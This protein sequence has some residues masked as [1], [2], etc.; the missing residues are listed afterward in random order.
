MGTQQILMIV[1][2]VIIVGAAVAVGIQMF[3]TQANNQAR[4]A[5]V[6]DLMQFGVQAQAWFRQPVVMGGPGTVGLTATNAP[7]M[8]AFINRDWT[9]GLGPHLNTTGSYVFSV[10]SDS[11]AGVIGTSVQNPAIQAAARINLRGGTEADGY[12]VRIATGGTIPGP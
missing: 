7:E 6:S 9:G 1:L 3:D 10:I 8:V 5:I 4:N 11:A 2:S 12:G